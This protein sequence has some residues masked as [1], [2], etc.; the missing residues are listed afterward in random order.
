MCTPAEPRPIPLT[1]LTHDAVNAPLFPMIPETAFRLLDIG[2]GTG[3]FGAALKESRP[4]L[5]V[6]GV[7]I[8]PAEAD[9]ARTRLDAVVV[10]DLNHDSIASLGTFDVITCSHVLG[11]FPRPESVLKALQKNLTPDGLLL[12]AIPN[13]LHWRQRLELLRG[14]FTY[15]DYGVLHRYYVRFF[16]CRSAY[17]TLEAAGYTI[18]SR[19]ADG[20]FPLPGLRRAAPRFAEAIDRFAVRWRPGLFAT[21]FLVA[22][23]ADMA[24]RQGSA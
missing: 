22:A 11:Y 9:E 23:T 15:V 19:R 8:S 6:T 24:A 3:T 4:H 20:Y 7:T 13:V 17:T 14:R 2:C 1:E 12:A 10:C 18:V 16:D 21:Q 5:S